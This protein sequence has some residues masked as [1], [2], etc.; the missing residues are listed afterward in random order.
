[1][2]VSLNDLWSKIKGLIKIKTKNKELKFQLAKCFSTISAFNGIRK[3][4]L[5]P[6]I[7]KFSNS[8]VFSSE[9][10]ASYSPTQRSLRPRIFKMMHQRFGRPIDRFGIKHW[11][12]LYKNLNMFLTTYAITPTRNLKTANFEYHGL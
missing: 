1:M 4:R 2:S 3:G 7:V 12:Q 8:C 6:K 11:L 10:S 9:N 5:N